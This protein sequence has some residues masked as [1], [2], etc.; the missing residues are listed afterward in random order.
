M[1]E[2]E[3]WTAQQAGQH[4]DGVKAA[5]YRD[6]TRRLGAP[7][8]VAIRRLDGRGQV[9]ENLYDPTAVK[10]W[11]AARRGSGWWGPHD[12][13]P[14]QKETTDGQGQASAAG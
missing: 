1:P 14:R 8:P 10:A 5:T 6:Y 7:G 12:S 9:G 2:P 13:E 3:L 11:H 4:C